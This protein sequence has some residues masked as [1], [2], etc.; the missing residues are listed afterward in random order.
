[1]YFYIWRSRQI[2]KQKKYC[3]QKS[4]KNHSRWRN[5]ILYDGWQI[6]LWG[7][8]VT[9]AECKWGDNF[10]N[11]NNKREGG[12]NIKF[13][14]VKIGINSTSSKMFKKLVRMSTK[15]HEKSP[16]LWLDEV[17]IEFHHWSPSTYKYA[18][19]LHLKSST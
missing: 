10:Y 2:E 18:N 1:M 6:V 13:Q 11:N 15:R 17:I 12:R 5:I 9:K 19:S 16:N 7:I 3:K 4:G 8:C 14:K